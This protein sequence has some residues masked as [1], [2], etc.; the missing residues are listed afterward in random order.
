M[1]TYTTCL[2]KKSPLVNL[3]VFGKVRISFKRNTF[4]C[5]FLEFCKKASQVP[6]SPVRVI[7]FPIIVSWLVY[8][9]TNNLLNNV[10]RKSKRRQKTRKPL[11]RA[12][13]RLRW[14]NSYFC[15]VL[16]TPETDIVIQV[17][18]LHEYPIRNS[19]SETRPTSYLSTC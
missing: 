8:V 1:Y 17:F 2:D 7:N 15:L 11:C 18:T 3:F 9:E 19:D 5:F 13:L 16:S 4:P 14:S 10:E 12:L 6:I